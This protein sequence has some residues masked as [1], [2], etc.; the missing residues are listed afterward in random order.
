MIHPCQIQLTAQE[1]QN[2]L[3]NNA[4]KENISANSIQERI[5]HHENNR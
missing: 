2:I 1:G 4:G 3:T 5:I